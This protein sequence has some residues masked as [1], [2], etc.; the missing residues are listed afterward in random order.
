MLSTG[1]G[2]PTNC[3]PELP[4]H[5]ESTT[6]AGRGHLSR[7]DGDGGVLGSDADAH[8]KACGEEALPRLGETR[9]DRGRYQAAGGDEDL[10][11]SSEVVVQG[12]DNK[13]ATRGEVRLH[14]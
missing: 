14:V 3:N 7:I 2:K 8:N 5:D 13:G 11:S 9:T 10:A 12:I 1:E 4:E 6:D